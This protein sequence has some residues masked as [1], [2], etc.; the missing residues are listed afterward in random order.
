MPWLLGPSARCWWLAPWKSSG[1]FYYKSGD[2]QW[3]DLYFDPSTAPPFDDSL[4]QNQF[5]LFEGY[6]ASMT[7]NAIARVA[8]C[9][10]TMQCPGLNRLRLGHS[11]QEVGDYLANLI[12]RRGPQDALAPAQMVP[13]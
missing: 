12:V 10:S 8:P 2:Q 7:T 4:W 9:E 11:V 13:I 3:Y 5:N 6:L 1:T